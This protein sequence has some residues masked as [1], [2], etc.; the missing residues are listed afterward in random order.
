MKKTLPMQIAG[1]KEDD[2]TIFITVN[3]TT[4]KNFWFGNHSFHQKGQK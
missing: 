2:E 4:Y 1:R 3:V